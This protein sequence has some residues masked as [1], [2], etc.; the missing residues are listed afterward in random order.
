MYY[1][2]RNRSASLTRLMIIF[3]L[4]FGAVFGILVWLTHAKL[5]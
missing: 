2:D 3:S 5:T 4:A 1:D